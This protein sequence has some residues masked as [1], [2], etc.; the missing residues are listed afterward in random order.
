[1]TPEE[2]A[3][4]VL[5]AAGLGDLAAPPVDALHL[6]EE[7][8]GLDVQEHADLLTL[9]GA[10]ALADGSMLSGLLFP[11]QRRIYVNA[12]EAQRSPGRRNFTIAH[13]LGHWHL[14]RSAGDDAHARFCRSD[15]VGGDAR[16]VKLASR[17][18]REANRFAA[19]LL[20][21]EPLVRAQAEELRLNVRLLAGRFGV[22]VLAMQV[23]LE[24]LNLL[25]DYMRR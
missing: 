10:P 20:M 6:A 3:I 17:I 13:E 24:S 9:P 23:R 11:A 22:S 16:A 25:P 5:V 2:A 4:A 8:D 7:H 14:H 12:V 1:M 18:E 19:A 15:D 21:P